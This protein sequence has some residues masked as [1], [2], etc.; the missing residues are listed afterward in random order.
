[1]FPEVTFSGRFRFELTSVRL[2]LSDAEMHRH[3][4]S[5]NVDF[6]NKEVSVRIMDDPG[7]MIQGLLD[8]VRDS[9][10]SLDAERIVARLEVLDAAW[11]ATKTYIFEGLTITHH[12]FGRFGYA[13]DGPAAHDLTIAYQTSRLV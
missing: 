3:V 11:K 1:M 2:K 13:F 12:V 6:A 10:P 8:A 9:D 4:E 5:V 7:G